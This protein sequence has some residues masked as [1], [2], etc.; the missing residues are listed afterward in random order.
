MTTNNISHSRRLTIIVPTYR[1]H[2]FLRRLITYYS[3]LP[4]DLIFAD[5]TEWVSGLPPSGQYGLAHWF[6]FNLPG[7]DTIIDRILSATHFVRTPYFCFLDDEDILLISGLKTAMSA[8]ESRTEINFCTGTV[9]QV[10]GERTLLDGTTRTIYSAWGHWSKP[11]FVKDTSASEILTLL[12][13][14]MRTANFYYVVMR[15]D[16][17]LPSIQKIMRLRTKSISAYELLVAGTVA[18][19]QPS[20]EIGNFPFWLR[21][22]SSVDHNIT[23]PDR[24]SEGDWNE[25]TAPEEYKATVKLL[26][27]EVNR[28]RGNSSLTEASAR[29]YFKLHSNLHNTPPEGSNDSRL[30]G[31]SKDA[32][33]ALLNRE[34]NSI[35][36]NDLA[37][38]DALFRIYPR[39]TEWI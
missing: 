8:L 10:L 39:G 33:I 11:M 22:N 37:D 6:Y 25:I 14:N 7:A 2:K 16:I 38:I 19:A 15:T 34:L 32:F 9:A 23:M 18:T 4:V 36:I 1:K 5:G 3:K 20:V 29:D 21:T 35:E 13:T 17:F 12:I 28:L 24:V 27:E 30:F 31:S 26:V